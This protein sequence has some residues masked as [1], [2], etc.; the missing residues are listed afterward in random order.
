MPGPHP[1]PKSSSHS[2]TSVSNRTG[3]NLVK[4]K[5][6]SQSRNYKE[7]IVSQSFPKKVRVIST[8]PDA[9]DSSSEEED[10]RRRQLVKERSKRL[11]QKILIADGSSVFSES[12]DDVESNSYLSTFEACAMQQ[13]LEPF[14][15]SDTGPQKNSLKLLEQERIQQEVRR[16]FPSSVK[17][18]QLPHH[19]PNDINSLEASQKATAKKSKLTAPK[20][21]PKYKG[22][23]Q[24]PWGKW[25]AEI[26]DPAKG[27]RL[28]LGTYETAEA[29]AEAYER[30][31]IK[32]KGSFASTNFVDVKHENCELSPKK[33]SQKATAKEDFCAS[34]GRDVC[35]T[36]FRSD[37][38]AMEF[39][40]SKLEEVTDRATG[41]NAESSLPESSLPDSST[42]RL[43]T[44]NKKVSSKE[45]DGHTLHHSS[46]LY[47]YTEPLPL[48]SSCALENHL[49]FV[50]S[51]EIFSPN[52]VLAR[53]P[54]GEFEYP[55]S[56]QERWH[57]FTDE[58]KIFPK[59]C[60]ERFFS[61]LGGFDFSGNE[62]ADNGISRHTAERLLEFDL[63][64]STIFSEFGN[65][66]S[67]MPPEN[68]STF[69]AQDEL[70]DIFGLSLL[71]KT[72]YFPVLD[73]D[74]LPDD[75]SVNI[76]S[77][78][79]VFTSVDFTVTFDE[80]CSSI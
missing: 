65:S 60:D 16:A 45:L 35:T 55:E 75:S 18:K 15:S 17:R 50:V 57:D 1:F 4:H 11:V 34:A 22:V 63:N 52:S 59:L 73:T 44:T 41:E 76:T 36:N 23:R 37:P 3:T 56:P 26:R 64:S 25:A 21:A 7:I 40:N 43:C 49:K 62:V 5:I 48:D 13:E 58:M 68:A 79:S 46:S 80:A 61:S 78:D 70:E 42:L 9:T 47:R 19:Q 2:K 39:Y 66:P 53:S 67:P 71:Q 8:D 38:S 29:A 69:F 12:D 31:A 27:V 30:A 51:N 72:N 33:V 32:I 14:N 6:L 20:K 74:L 77:L 28:W 24:R 54:S 10:F